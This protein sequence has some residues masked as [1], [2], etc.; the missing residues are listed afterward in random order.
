MTELTTFFVTLLGFVTFIVIM[1][2]GY[3]VA[4][5]KIKGSCGGL[6]A[7]VTND[8]GEKVCGFCGIEVTDP[9]VQNCQTSQEKA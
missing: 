2:V 9:A 4:G 6:N 5:K 7:A 1:S 8:A 3:W